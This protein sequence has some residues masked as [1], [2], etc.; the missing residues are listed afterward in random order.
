MPAP[1]PTTR[2]RCAICKNEVYRNADGKV[3]MHTTPATAAFA[4]WGGSSKYKP[5]EVCPGSDRG[6]RP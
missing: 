2:S 3:L 5:S 1:R 4:G 6:A